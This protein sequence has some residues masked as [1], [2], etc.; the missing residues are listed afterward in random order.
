MKA[1]ITNGERNFCNFTFLNGFR[2]E[3]MVPPWTHTS[4]FSKPV[5]QFILF[6]GT[7]IAY[8]WQK[9]P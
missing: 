7:G 1:N 6:H 5:V 2:K 3:A 4:K 9:S 8:G